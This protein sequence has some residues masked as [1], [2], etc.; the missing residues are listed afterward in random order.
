M[1][2]LA[3]VALAV[4]CCLSIIGSVYADTLK[5]GETV[6]TRC[7]LRPD[8]TTLLF[9]NMSAM[10]GRI[11]AGSEAK[12]EKCRGGIIVFDDSSTNKQY[13]IVVDC[14]QWNKFFVKNKNEISSLVNRPQVENGEAVVGMTKEEVYASKGCPAYIAWGKTSQKQS[15]DEVMQSDK[16]YYMT[17]SRGHDTMVTFENGVAVKTGGYE[18]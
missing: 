2:K 12:I 5:S 10:K 4:V 7:N 9:H 14:N 8:G 6:Y 17:N 16:W 3:L 18:K 11:P 1:R 13:R 15:F